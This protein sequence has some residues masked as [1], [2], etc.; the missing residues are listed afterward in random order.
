MEHWN[1]PEDLSSFL[2]FL[3]NFG[4]ALAIR[5][6]A[7]LSTPIYPEAYVLQSRVSHLRSYSRSS[8]C[9]V[10]FFFSISHLP[11]CL[12]SSIH[13]ADVVCA[14]YVAL[15]R[16]LMFAYGYSIFY[17]YGSHCRSPGMVSSWI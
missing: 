17:S 6:D 1:I 12:R 2:R 9:Q 8:A 10:L 5:R 7:S 15:Q 14:R 4:S 3:I 11:V 13:D 16:A